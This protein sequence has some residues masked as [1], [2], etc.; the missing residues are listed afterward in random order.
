MNINKIIKRKFLFLIERGY[1]YQKI[2]ED[3]VYCELKFKK[4]TFSISL[5]FD[6]HN[7]FLD[8]TIKEDTK[9]LLKTNYDCVVEDDLNWEKKKFS[10]LLKDI[11]KLQ[12]DSNSYS[13]SQEQLVNLLDLYANFI[14]ETAL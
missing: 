14:S 4:N 10:Q 6:C 9:T 3:K 8:L 12:R 13:L 2:V 7:E 5:Q 1:L 11:Y